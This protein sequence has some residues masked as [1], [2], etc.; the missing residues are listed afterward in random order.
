MK[1]SK[2]I[3]QVILTIA[4]VLFSVVAFGQ[5]N[6]DENPYSK[7]QFRSVRSDANKSNP[8]EGLD[9][10]TSQD[11]S[12]ITMQSGMNQDHL[13]AN[14]DRSEESP[15]DRQRAESIQ[16]LATK[17]L[18]NS[19]NPF[20]QQTTICYEVER[21]QIINLSIFYRGH[22]VTTLISGRQEAGE[23]SAVFDSMKLPAGTYQAVLS[24]D[25][26]RITRN[27]Y[28]VQ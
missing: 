2:T 3:Q 20:T 24:V 18:R 25:G 26:Q 6:G 23:Y 1:T 4:V 8:I 9:F 21:T 17:E 11:G 10:A 27:M 13:S 14:I 16:D 28:K 5:N 12:L 19:P 15:R 7:K 22:L